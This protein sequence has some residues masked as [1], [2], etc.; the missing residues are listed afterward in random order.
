MPEI[1][2]SPA[3]PKIKDAVRIR[4]S[5]STEAFVVEGFHLVE[6]AR[7]KNLLCKVFAVKDPGFPEVDTVLVPLEIIEKISS[8]KTPEPILG[9]ARLP[10][11]KDS[12]GK[13]VLLLDRLQDPGNVGT[14]IRTALAFGFED[15]VFAP[16]TCSPMNSKSIAAS[17]GAVFGAQLHFLKDSVSFVEALKKDGY[18]IIGSALKDSRSLDGFAV[19]KEEPMVLIIGNEGQGMSESLLAIC[20][21]VVRIPMGNIDSLNAAI[22]GGILMER[23]SIFH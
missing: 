11:G 8:S 2:T 3:N 6:M 5:P 20:D 22:A 23:F 7:E 16:G 21:D 4:K 9:I 17:Q 18:R 12:L 10:K 15:V 14:L 1:I 19:S 13:R